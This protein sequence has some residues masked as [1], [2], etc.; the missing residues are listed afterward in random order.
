MGNFWGG[1]YIKAKTRG[2]RGHGL[3][4][5]RVQCQVCSHCEPHDCSHGDNTSPTTYERISLIWFFLCRSLFS[6]CLPRASFLTQPPSPT[7]S[8]PTKCDMLWPLTYWVI[9]GYSA[10]PLRCL[11]WHVDFYWVLRRYEKN[12][13][14]IKIVII[15][16]YSTMVVR[17][18]CAKAIF[19][20]H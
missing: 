16:V 12:L 19:I 13:K 4:G 18:R 14:T 3:L 6:W 2:N 10:R 7:S 11:S 8:N 9:W 17:L 15:C 1:T 20:V 5:L